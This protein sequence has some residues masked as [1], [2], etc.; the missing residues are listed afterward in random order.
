M[1]RFYALGGENGRVCVVGYA[2]CDIDLRWGSRK[3]WKAV[4]RR[5][6]MIGLKER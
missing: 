3:R 5:G 1:C 4:D 6:A 2:L